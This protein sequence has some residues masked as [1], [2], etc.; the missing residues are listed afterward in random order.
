MCVDLRHYLD[1]D[2]VRMDNP[3]ELQADSL[4]IKSDAMRI[5]A[6]LVNIRVFRDHTNF[7][8]FIGKVVVPGGAAGLT[9]RRFAEC[10]LD[11]AASFFVLK[12]LPEYTSSHVLFNLRFVYQEFFQQCPNLRPILG[13]FDREFLTLGNN[14]DFESWSQARLNG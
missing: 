6:E 8:T 10:F 2:S 9:G 4:Q 11:C 7:A 5:L 3:V 1:L 13:T 14:R 12:V